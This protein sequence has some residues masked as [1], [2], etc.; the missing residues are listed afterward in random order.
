MPPDD[1][2]AEEAFSPVDIKSRIAAFSQAT[3]TVQSVSTSTLRPMQ[4]VLRKTPSTSQ[5]P[6]A[7]QK[8]QLQQAKKEEQSSNTTGSYLKPSHALMNRPRSTSGDFKRQSIEDK[9]SGSSPKMGVKKIVASYGQKPLM[10]SVI[11]AASSPS[12]GR[13]ERVGNL[14]DDSFEGSPLQTDDLDDTTSR[15]SDSTMQVQPPPAL[16]PRPRGSAAI[17]RSNTGSSTTSSS[18]NGLS[19]GNPGGSHNANSVYTPY[20]R[21]APLGSTTTTS[22]SSVPALPPRAW[23]AR[24][25]EDLTLNS[26]G[27]SRPSSIQRSAMAVEPSWVSSSTGNLISQSDESTSSAMPPPAIPPR[28]NPALTS[29][30]TLIPPPKRALVSVT[31]QGSPGTASSRMPRSTSGSAA[32]AVASLGSAA[33]S[34]GTAVGVGS[35]AHHKSRS[36]TSSIPASGSASTIAIPP[37]PRHIDARRLGQGT[38]IATSSTSSLRSVKQARRKKET[39]RAALLYSREADEAEERYATLFDQQTKKQRDGGTD[40]RDERLN[41]AAVMKVW[42]CSQLEEWF[43]TRVWERASVPSVVGAKDNEGL[44]KM[45]FV[46]A[47]SAIDYE[48]QRRKEE[49]KA[50]NQTT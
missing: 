6:P 14:L 13:Q 19:A 3:S 46:R 32:I 22:V 29:S 16:P 1:E 10:E 28:V 7:W 4:P 38:R 49:R 2:K 26:S 43:L 27:S 21:K 44:T 17:S 30:A 41:K 15:N 11:V 42:R 39:K 40:G 8:V 20:V 31:P 25:S 48:L 50:R 5:I 24:S 36:S 9:S 33:A 34:S 12:S 45:A 18:S 37:P 23:A 47:M 35:Q